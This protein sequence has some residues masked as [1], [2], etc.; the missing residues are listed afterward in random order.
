MYI[1]R[2]Y[3]G[4]GVDAG[5]LCI[6]DDSDNCAWG[7]IAAG[8]SYPQ[9]LYS[10]T[11]TCIEWATGSPGNNKQTTTSSDGLLYTNYEYKHQ[12]DTYLLQN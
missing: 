9:I 1:N 7:Q 11:A 8:K 3:G 10:K 4:C 6:N 12:K 5:W 2:N